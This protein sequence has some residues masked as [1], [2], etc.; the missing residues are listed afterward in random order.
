MRAA[1]E[2]ASEIKRR[3]TLLW[4][5]TMGAIVLTPICANAQMLFSWQGVGPVQLGMTVQGAESAL[6][7]KLRPVDA[8]FSEDCYVTGRADGKEEALSYVVI[9]GKIAVMTVFPRNE[10]R[11]DPNI[12]DGSGIGV[13]SK[14]A[15]I[16]RAYGNV[17]KELAPDFRLSKEEI[18]E[19][20]KERT[21]R[22]PET[23][24]EYRIVVENSDHKRV[25]KFQT[26]NQK[27]LYFEIGLQP[28]IMSSEHCI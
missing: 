16:R 17:R 19:A 7:A 15:D 12:V 25:I 28:E 26:W 9:D 13:G 3:A 8:P 1:S 24:P 14:E 20:A 18:V 21:K 6:N 23:S 2:S 11:P 5:F 4:F 27:V 22:K 10:H